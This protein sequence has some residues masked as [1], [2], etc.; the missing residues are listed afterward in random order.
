MDDHL[1]NLFRYFS[2]RWEECQ[3]LRGEEKTNKNMLYSSYLKFV[4]SDPV[5]LWKLPKLLCQPH[6]FVEVFWGNKIHS[7]FGA[8]LWKKGMNL[9][10]NYTI[11][12]RLTSMKP[13]ITLRFLTWCGQPAGMKTASPSLCSKVHG[14]IPTYTIQFIAGKGE[15]SKFGFLSMF[16]HTVFFLELLFVIP[17]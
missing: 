17:C 9:I 8:W 10:K 16:S 13:L 15:A 6:A 11:V 4:F 1:L 3:T 14:S 12:W 7:H 5:V 2:W